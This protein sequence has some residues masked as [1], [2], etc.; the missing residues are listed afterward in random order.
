[1]NGKYMVKKKVKI[2]HIKTL[3]LK[4]PIHMS[5][6]LTA[7][8]LK[9]E[10]RGCFLTKFFFVMFGSGK[11]KTEKRVGRNASNHEDVS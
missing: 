5:I 7:I 4:Q 2:Q 6:N 11:S 1:M 9:I 8:S 10:S 3:T